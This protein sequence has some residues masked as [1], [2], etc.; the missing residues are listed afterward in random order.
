MPKNF[1]KWLLI[2]AL[3]ILLVRLLF[4]AGIIDIVHPP[5]H[6]YHTAMARFYM[7]HP[8]ALFIWDLDKLDWLCEI[9]YIGRLPY[10][11]TSPNLYANLTGKLLFL[12]DLFL[13]NERLSLRIV[14]HLQVIFGLLNI[15]YIYAISGFVFKNKLPRVF[16]LLI[17]T[18]IQMFSYL[19]NF[20]TYDNLV[21]LA[22]SASIFYLLRFIR[23]KQLR[24]V[25]WLGFFIGVGSL[26]KFT[27][28]VLLVLI[29][30]VFLF[31]FLRHFTCLK[32]DIKPY[33]LDKRNLFINLAAVVFIL[34]NLV[35][36]G[37]NLLVHHTLVRSSAQRH[38]ELAYCSTYNQA[39][40]PAAPQ[41]PPMD[42]STSETQPG[43]RQ[44]PGAPL[45]LDEIQL[46]QPSTAVDEAAPD[47]IT[48]AAESDDLTHKAQQVDYLY[49]TA[50]WFY[51]MLNRTINIAS[52]KSLTKPLPYTLAFAALFALSVLLFL[53][54]YRWKQRDLNLLLY[55]LLGYTA[56]LFYYKLSRVTVDNINLGIAG[57]YNFPVIASFVILF[58]FSFWNFF[59]DKKIAAALLTLI[60]AFFVYA[61]T[62]YLFKNFQVWTA[63]D[64]PVTGRE[65]PLL[66]PSQSSPYQVFYLDQGNSSKKIGLYISTRHRVIRGGYRFNL[67]DQDC[68]VLLDSVEL[69]Q[70][71]NNYNIITF[72]HSLAYD[73]PYCFNITN[74][75]NPTP[76]QIWYASKDLNGYILGQPDQDILYS[77]VISGYDFLE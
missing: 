68:A 30:P 31:Y 61:D 62:I 49:F 44:S 75:S 6:G 74:V 17:L 59:R 9:N 60:A 41:Q 53:L 58:V 46:D 35:F 76:I 57:R 8:A 52:H 34:L 28:G 45:P 19:F 66:Y 24:D 38:A 72:N 18:N 40:Q 14:E 27:F 11:T 22:S 43:T 56:Y 15:A 16:V 23:R 26:T 69:N 42:A 13:N 71:L 10:L 48:P 67:Y 77:Q 32:K 37:R 64:S 3:A 33:L 1:T 39:A 20:L 4:Y 47:S 36:Y 55:L 51:N 7:R 54:R 73:Q 70:I 29:L 63:K 65:L 25:A 2:A 21:N 5:D 12:V 50:R